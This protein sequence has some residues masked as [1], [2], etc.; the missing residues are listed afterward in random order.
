MRRMYVLLAAMLVVSFAFATPAFAT[1]VG[2]PYD[3]AEERW[4]PAVLVG[5]E[6]VFTGDYPRY[7]GSPLPEFPFFWQVTTP[8]GGIMQSTAVRTTYPTETQAASLALSGHDCD[9]PIW[10]VVE[11]ER[12]GVTS[13]ISI[14]ITTRLCW[15]C[16]FVWN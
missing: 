15:T 13:P 11:H 6:P 1:I 16:G 10:I 8:D 2:A 3:S 7:D 9:D 5:F 4:L 14:T 12:L